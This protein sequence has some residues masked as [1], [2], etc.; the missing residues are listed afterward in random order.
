MI[1]SY[2]V[3]NSIRNKFD[4]LCDLIS[5]NVDIPSVAETKLDPELNLRKEKWLFVSIYEP[6]LQNNYYF[7]G[8]LNDLLDVYSVIFDNKVVF[9]ISTQNL[10]IQL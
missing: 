8:T 2:I 7:L 4:N 6:P 5:K 10:L 1:F 9:G 3:I